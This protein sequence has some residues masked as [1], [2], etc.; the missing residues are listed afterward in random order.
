MSVCEEYENHTLGIIRYFLFTSVCM[1][2]FQTFSDMSLAA[3]L[4]PEPT[5][6]LFGLSSAIDTSTDVNSK[7]QVEVRLRHV[8]HTDI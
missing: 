4:N 2:G 7:S 3:S 6:I 8:W 5:Q 1:M